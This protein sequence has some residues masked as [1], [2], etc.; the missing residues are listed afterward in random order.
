MRNTWAKRLKPPFE[1]KEFDGPSLDVGDSYI[2]LCE[3]TRAICRYA[4]KHDYDWLLIVD[5]DVFVRVENLKV[6]EE[7]DYVGRRL[8]DDLLS[9]GRDHYC[10]GGFYWLSRCAFEIVAR[11]HLSK[12]TWAEDRWVGQLLR[13]A[14]IRPTNDDMAKCDPMPCKCITCRPVPRSTRRKYFAVGHFWKH[15]DKPV[16]K[17]PTEFTSFCFAHK[18]NLEQYLELEKEYGDP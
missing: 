13:D 14:G 3:K 2:D 12:E 15:E 7:G 6:P 18:W 17:M 11:S 9:N 1:Y 8:P 5:D 10:S 4:V 16:W